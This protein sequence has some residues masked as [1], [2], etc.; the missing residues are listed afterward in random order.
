MSIQY[1]FPV[2]PKSKRLA[3][4]KFQRKQIKEEQLPPVMSVKEVARFL[5]VNIKTVYESVNKGELPAK[6]LG[7]RWI[8]MRD[9][10]LEW[11]SP[12]FGVRSGVNFGRS[13]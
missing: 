8:I 5:G 4:I 12:S 1:L 2:T 6:K 3:I 7:R 10:M 11:L 9:I 13:S